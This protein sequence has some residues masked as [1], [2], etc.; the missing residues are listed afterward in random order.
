MSELQQEPTSTQ[1]EGRYVLGDPIADTRAPDSPVG[2]R[3]DDRKFSARLVNPANRRKM[4]R[5]RRRH[6]PG[7]RRRGGHAGRG[8][9]QREVLLLPGLARGARTPSPRRAAST[10]P[11]TTRTTAT[12]STASSTTRS[13]AATSA[14]ARRTSTASPRSAVNIID[15]CVAQGVPFAREYGGP[16]RQPLVRRRAGLAHVLRARPD[17]PAAAARRVPGARAPDRGRHR[18]DAPAHRDA[19]PDRRRRPRAR[20]RRA[21]PA[22]PARSRRTSP[23]PSCSA[24]AATATSSTSRPTPRAR[25]VTAIWRAHK[26]GAL[27]ANPC[28]T[29]IH[30]TCIPVS[31]DYQSKLTLMSRVAAQR[32]PRLGAEGARRRPRRPNE[33]PEDERDYYLERKYPS[34]GNLVP[35]DIASRAAKDVCDAGRGVGPGGL[36]VYLDFADAI[37]RLGRA[38]PSRRKYG[39]LFEMYQRITGENPYEVPMRIYPAIHYTMGGLWVDYNLQ[40]DHPRA[41]SWSARRTSPTTAPTGSAPRALMQGLAD[42]YFILPTTMADYLADAPFEQVPDDHPAVR[43]AVDVDARP[44]RQ[45]ALGINGNRTVDSFHRELGKLMWDQCGMA[46]SKEGLREG[47]RPDPVAARGVLARRQDRRDR[48]RLQPVAG[49]GQPGGR[50]HGAR[51]SSCASTRCTARSR[52][53]ATSASSTRPRTARRARDDENFSYVAAWEW[54]RR[55]QAD[56]AQGGPRVRVRP[57]E[58]AR[59]TSKR[60]HR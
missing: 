6:R 18:R 59:A 55:R 46:R 43:E 29:Q 41:C 54:R 26:R 7:R 37:K 45:A 1:G 3:W 48:G 50:L 19:R 58:P 32:R 2:D 11:R 15:Q 22:S 30:P 40:L 56:P 8:R 27:F 28:Y 31:G 25:N 4:T 57:P 10:P 60:H 13:R 47:A 35:R 24:P 17:G 52:A 9:L 20:H 49:E 21:Q 53:A 39:N 23:T 36:G 14:R 44:H 34:F 33:I 38:R 16:A 42:G 51:A 5:H 12:A